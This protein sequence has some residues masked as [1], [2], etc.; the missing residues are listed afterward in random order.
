MYCP[1]CGSVTNMDASYCTS[2]HGIN[3]F[4]NEPLGEIDAECSRC[5]G[6]GGLNHDFGGLL[7][8]CPSCN[9]TGWIRD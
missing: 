7:V 9:G 8:A 4:G 3:P 6:K 5:K 1:G 2:C